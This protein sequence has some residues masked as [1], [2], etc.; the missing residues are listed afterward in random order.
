MI[1]RVLIGTAIVACGQRDP[2]P[3]E[4]VVVEPPAWR[5]IDASTPTVDGPLAD[6]P[7]TRAPPSIVDAPIAW[8]PR[9]EQLT[10]AYRRAHHDRAARDL[11]IE[12]TAIVLH[13][14]GGDSA[15]S[16][17]RYFDNVEI[18][19]ERADL[20][21]AGVVNVSA[22]FLVDHD[23]TIYQLQP[24]TRYARHCIGLNHVA[25]GI[26]NVGDQRTLTDAQVT[27]DAALIR[28]LAT[29]HAIGYLLGHYEVMGMRK[30][31]HPLYVELDGNYRNS[32][33]DPGEEFMARV[34]HAVA[35]L[36]L[37]GAE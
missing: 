36:G 24:T 20:R 28:H 16:T 6:A 37:T 21:R 5:P 31:K 19:A 30:R 33:P 13:Y 25:I 11:V 17:R 35:D 7:P 14:T 26:E 4:P 9:R 12:P 22:H 32:K 18:E 15:A 1:C 27:A 2:G 29:R 8:G 34:R 23:G 10:L 3:G